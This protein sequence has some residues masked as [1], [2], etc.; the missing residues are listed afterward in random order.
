MVDEKILNDKS[1]WKTILKDWSVSP[2]L[3]GR[4]EAR[5]MSLLLLPAVSVLLVI[6]VVKVFSERYLVAILLVVFSLLLWR[7]VRHIVKTRMVRPFMLLCLLIGAA[8]MTYEA[9][10]YDPVRPLIASAIFPVLAYFYLGRTIGTLFS[11]ALFG[12]IVLLL[13]VF[14]PTVEPQ[15]A[16]YILV[17]YFMVALIARLYEITRRKTEQALEKLSNTDELTG[18]FNRRVLDQVLK[19]EISR[20]HRQLLP[21]SLCMMDF[22]DFKEVNDIYGHN[23]GDRVLWQ[24]CQIVQKNIRSTDYLI[25]YGGDE[26]VVVTPSADTEHAKMVMDKISAAVGEFDFGIEQPIKTSIGVAELKDGDN[27]DQLL[28]RADK[29]LY[30]D[31]NNSPPD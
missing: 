21:L 4:F 16:I 15:N 30:D 6:A 25:R 27:I 23:L 9:L 7:I 1:G 29:A 24:F 13:F 3:R 31:K 5:S 8:I 18:A 26:F 22:N 11:A 19:R 28:I 17:A 2:T 10:A 14:N 12:L 20:S